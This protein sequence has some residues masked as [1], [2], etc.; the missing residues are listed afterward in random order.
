MLF[1]ETVIE[2]LHHS[3]KENKFKQLFLIQFHTFYVTETGI[4]FT[5]DQIDG[6]CKDIRY[7]DEFFV[8]LIFDDS[9]AAIVSVYED[10]VAKWKNII[11]DFILKSYKSNSNPQC[12]SISERQPV[13]D[14]HCIDEKLL[15]NK[16]DEKSKTEL[17]GHEEDLLSKPNTLNKAEE[18]LQKF[19]SK[20]MPD[21]E[22]EDE[23]DIEDYL[24]GLE[25]KTN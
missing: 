9:K 20:H 3:L 18:I 8:D 16:P 19:G 2:V 5:R 22:E 23:D 6:V 25:N 13:K 24:K 17:H 21:E 12:K 1:G 10:E 11:S 14:S 15:E 7:P 4:R